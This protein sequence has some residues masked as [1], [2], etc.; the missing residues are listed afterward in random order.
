MGYELNFSNSVSLGTEVVF[1]NTLITPNSLVGAEFNFSQVNETKIYPMD[2]TFAP[3]TA[4]AGVQ[5]III[6]SDVDC[7]VTFRDSNN[8]S[9][10]T[11]ASIEG[12][13]TK[14]GARTD[15]NG[16]IPFNFTVPTTGTVTSVAV[17]KTTSSGISNTI[18][19][20]FVSIWVY[21][22]RQQS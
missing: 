20:G 8:A 21:Y 17:Q 11:V 2:F 18:I 5:A 22:N 19:T 10:L 9:L 6:Q 4:A 16:S 7:S 14:I 13:E 1:S 15:A 12:G 3:V